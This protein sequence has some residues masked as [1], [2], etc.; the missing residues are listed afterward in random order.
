MPERQTSGGAIALPKLDDAIAPT[1]RSHQFPLRLTS[2][3]ST[4]APYLPQR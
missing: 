1:E 3:P 2:I 4:N